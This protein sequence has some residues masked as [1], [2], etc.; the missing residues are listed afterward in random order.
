MASEKVGLCVTNGMRRT[1]GSEELSGGALLPAPA[2]AAGPNTA[3][4]LDDGALTKTSLAAERCVDAHEASSCCTSFS[5]SASLY[6]RSREPAEWNLPSC[7]DCFPPALALR[8][9]QER[10]VDLDADSHAR[11]SASARRSC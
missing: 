5:S 10:C 7:L 3:L 11:T 9:G 6:A 4:L 1:R 2:T 8:G